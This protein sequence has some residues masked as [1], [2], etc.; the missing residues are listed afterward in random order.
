MS[1]RFVE[2]LAS[3][4][5]TATGVCFAMCASSAHGAVAASHFG[6]ADPATEGW[7]L[8][9]ETGGTSVG[10][11]S[12]DLDFNSVNAWEIGTIGAGGNYRNTLSASET[13]DA[14]ANGWRLTGTMRLGTGIDDGGGFTR[15]NA[16]LV[17]VT[18]E[19]G[20]SVRAGMDLAADPADR[21]VEERITNTI[22]QL[23]PDDYYTF[24]FDYDTA[25]TVDYYID[26]A[27]QNTFNTG[28]LTPTRVDFGVLNAA[29]DTNGARSFSFVQLE[30]CPCPPVGTQDPAPI[31]FTWESTSGDWNV[32]DNW[33]P[34]F[35]APS[36]PP[37][38]PNALQSSHHTATFGDSIGSD[39]R[40]VFTDEAVTVNRISFANTMGGSYRI[41]GGPSMNLAASTAISPAPA[42]IAVAQGSHVFQVPVNLLDDTTVDVGSSSTLNFDGALSLGGNTLTK[43]GTGTMAINNIIT[44]D[45]GTVLGLEGTISGGGTI[46][47]DV[48]NSGGTLSPGISSSASGGS[49]VPEPS[50]LALVALGLL[51]LV[52]LVRCRNDT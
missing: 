10:P 46:G 31:D 24:V 35:P 44:T 28:T 37:G 38:N 19:L 39:S 18:N 26:N 50:T 20:L 36:A 15:G 11:L 7:V 16:D 47:G 6:D 33:T 23:G 9:E 22:T 45:G 32:A 52:A 13:A 21:Q 48:N 42:A 41:A 3:L 5:L 40:T 12:P 49:V 29:A 27:L 8:F 34:T 17:V 1:P 4:I 14:V 30:T 25:G 2:I 43:T 51:G